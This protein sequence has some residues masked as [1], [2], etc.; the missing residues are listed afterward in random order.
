[1]PG[2]KFKK[3]RNRSSRQDAFYRRIPVLPRAFSQGHEIISIHE[4]LN[5]PA[6]EISDAGTLQYGDDT[7]QTG[8]ILI[9]GFLFQA[10]SRHIRAR[11]PKTALFEVYLPQKESTL[12]ER[13]WDFCILEIQEIIS[14]HRSCKQKPALTE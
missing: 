12:S 5:N 13:R 6:D 9:L 3:V 1:M 14:H 4:E 8:G 2:I 11:T 7:F 10:I